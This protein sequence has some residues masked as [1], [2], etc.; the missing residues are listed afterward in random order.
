[1]FKFISKCT[2]T[3]ICNTLTWPQQLSHGQGSLTRDYLIGHWHK[4]LGFPEKKPFDWSKVNRLVGLTH[5]ELTNT[6]IFLEINKKKKKTKRLSIENF[7]ADELIFAPKTEFRA[8]IFLVQRKF[9]T[10]SIKT[11]NL[12]AENKKAFRS[13][14]M[15]RVWCVRCVFSMISVRISD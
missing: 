3:N 14:I 12:L 15:R 5:W 8:H 6:K 7:K 13:L 10:C 9:F 4:R 11:R 2:K 1:M